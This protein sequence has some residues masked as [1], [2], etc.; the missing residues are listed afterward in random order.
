MRYALKKNPSHKTSY[1]ESSS[2][3]TRHE[4]LAQFLIDPDVGK[5]FGV[6]STSK[7]AIDGKRGRK[8]WLTLNQLASS[9][10]Y[11]SM[12]DAT[13]IAED[14]V[15]RPHSSPSMAARGK[16]EY[17]VEITEEMWER[18]NKYDVTVKCETEL[19]AQEYN[20]VKQSMDQQGPGLTPRPKKPKLAIQDMQPEER[21]KAE[22][23][24]QKKKDSDA[25]RGAGLAQENSR[26][27]E[28]GGIDIAGVC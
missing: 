7:I 24:E 1:N 27:S 14:C 21:A 2:D 5:C 23:L 28:K 15:S 11:N 6:Q 8:V 3:K 22:A 25:Q 18:L 13:L 20:D 17:H 19:T 9:T 4:W 26:E 16:K 12:E 10:M